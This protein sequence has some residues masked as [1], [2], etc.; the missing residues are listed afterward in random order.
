MSTMSNTPGSSFGNDWRDAVRK[1]AVSTGHDLSQG[2]IDELALHLEDLYNASRS[3][4][5]D[6][7]EAC[8]KTLAALEASP[9]H[10]LTS[11]DAHYPRR[12]EAGPAETKRSLNVTTSLRM[13]LRQFRQHPT[14]A[15]LTVVVMG[16]GV[17]AATTI[18]TILESVVLRP[19]PYEEP[20]RLVTIWDTNVAEGHLHDPISPVNFSDQRDLPVFEDAA[21]WWRP[22]VNLVDPGL[23]PIRVNTIEVS[24]NL[25]DVLGVRP[26]VGAG[27]PQGGPL[28]V[29][30]E[31]IAVISDRLWRRRYGADPS[32]I[33]K[34]LSFNDTPYTITGVMPK[35]FHYP[36]DIDVWERLRWDMTQHSRQARFMEAVARLSDGT[37][38][39]QAQSAIDSLWTR[40][41]TETA[42]TNNST[43]PGWGSGLIPLL[44]E[45]LGYYRPALY[46]LVGA[47]GL[48]LI[49]GVLNIA[50][51]L[52]TRGLSREREVAVRIAMGASP[53]QLVAQMMAESFVLSLAGA[54]AGVVAAAV[55]LP[56][57]VQRMPVEI[58]RLAEAG[59]SWA[60]LGV[61]F[62]IAGVTALFFGLVPA[63]LLLRRQVTTDLKSG[64]RGSS[65]GA[66]RFYSLLVA[67][68]VALACALLTSSALLVRT[69]QRMV[70]TPTG[71]NADHVL[72]T[73]VQLASD[74]YN[75]WEV[76]ADT[77]TRIV[78]HIRLQPGVEA[79]GASNFLPF[80][81]GWRAPFAIQGDE[82]PA[83]IDDLPQAQMHSVTDGYFESMGA[84]LAAGRTFTPFDRPDTPGVTIVNE[85]FA[86]QYLPESPAVG[87]ILS[88]YATGVGPLGRNLLGSQSPSAMEVVGVIRDIRNAPLGQPTEAA[89]YLPSRQFPFREQF[90]TVRAADTGAAL[91]AVENALRDVAP[92]VPIAAARTWG[93]RLS[94]RTAEPR[95][96]MTVLLFFGILA[97]LLAALGV[98]GILSWSVALR[99]REIAIRLTLGAQPARVGALVVR[100]SGVLVAI[101]VLLGLVII[102]L[103]ES[104]LA[105]VLF[106]VSP[107]DA[108]ST[109]A[110]T[111]LLLLAALGACVPP[112][113]RAMRVDPV[114]G[115]RAE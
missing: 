68:E 110:A 51:L 57:L 93:D 45:Q 41:E 11:R 30:N 87:R 60:S 3:A 73:M 4:G 55:A 67:A 108:G 27:F 20:D 90:L 31:L 56:L 78:E 19:L 7:E 106:E 40:L 13:A 8:A 36:D 92:D 39:E 49:I 23:D 69:V 33:G 24:G 9:L 54:L 72:T 71:V 61:G 96:L 17:G 35:R 44:H 94:E 65:R 53:R 46:V 101:G 16:L 115:L 62:G 63:L 75:D 18:Y 79:V 100:Q 105:S 22:G 1:K 91:A 98:Y 109:A 80:G 113:L 84:T 89:F 25:F 104:A 12:L 112:A 59:I 26:Q 42:D 50:A 107:R 82:P 32:I 83:H 10:L 111:G 77:H 5:A 66:R 29:P 102:R 52:L 103:G 48:L 6:D 21:A 15:I 76:V 14:F 47:V 38:I 88:I 95:L 64:E 37:T 97:A 114:E 74:A 86:R 2:T 28:F 58:P 34:Q 43:G 85:S 99:R 81:V 70:D